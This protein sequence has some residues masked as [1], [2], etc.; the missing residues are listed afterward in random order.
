MGLL[1]EPRRN[2]A[3]SMAGYLDKPAIL[4]AMF[5]DLGINTLSNIATNSLFGVGAAARGSIYD[6][7]KHKA[8]LMSSAPPPPPTAL[9]VPIAATVMA[10]TM[11]ATV[12]A[13]G[14]ATTTTVVGVSTATTAAAAAAAAA[15]TATAVDTIN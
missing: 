3:K 8:N 14:A 15:A 10:A 9:Y 6:V 1:V 7:A 5:F 11:P 2:M 13:A 4:F 12:T